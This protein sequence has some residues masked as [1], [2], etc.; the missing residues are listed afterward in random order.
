MENHH[1]NQCGGD[2]LFSFMRTSS[3]FQCNLFSCH[4]HC[5]CKWSLQSV[6]DP[7]FQIFTHCLRSYFFLSVSIC[8]HYLFERPLTWSCFFSFFFFHILKN[9]FIRF[10]FFHFSFFL[11]FC[12]RR[13]TI[14]ECAGMFNK[15]QT[16]GMCLSTFGTFIRFNWQCASVASE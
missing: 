1:W 16:V 4:C 5:H 12:S 9:F 14:F 11:P 15:Q 10:F 8:N 13:F 3:V 6:I 7:T 2:L